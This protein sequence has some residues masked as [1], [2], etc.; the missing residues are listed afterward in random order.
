M[1]K[2]TQ[3]KKALPAVLIG[4]VLFCATGCQNLFEPDTA[5]ITFKNNSRN[6]TY[7][8][9]L[10]GARIGSI[11]PDHS[12]EREVAQGS[13]TVEFQFANTQ[14][15]ACTTA[16]P[17]LAAGESTQFSCSRDIGKDCDCDL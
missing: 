11:A 7:D 6:T 16:T 1:T 17:N 3:L 5:T 15:L 10:D 2:Q 9:I 13:H 14:T 8:C 12:I 4:A